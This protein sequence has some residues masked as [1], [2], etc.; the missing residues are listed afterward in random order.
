MK[1]LRPYLLLLLLTTVLLSGCSEKTPEQQAI[2]TVIQSYEALQRGDYETFLQGRA[3]MDSIPADY[4]EQLLTAYKQFAHQ[5]CEA[6]GG[7][8]DFAVSRT[9]T[10]TLNSVM[11]VF[12]L[13]NYADS[14]REEIVV[15]MVQ[16]SEGLWKMK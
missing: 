11:Q 10:D 12:L 13:L 14:T 1:T 9:E 4:R 15:P 5:Q 7:I 6:H 2:D 3:G 16:D 8:N